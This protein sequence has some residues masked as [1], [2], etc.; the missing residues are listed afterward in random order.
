MSRSPKRS[1]FRDPIQIIVN[2]EISEYERDDYVYDLLHRNPLVFGSGVGMNNILCMF[3]KMSEGVR[4]NGRAYFDNIDQIV[5]AFMDMKLGGYVDVSHFILSLDLGGPRE[6]AVSVIKRL[7]ECYLLYEL[8]DH[9]GIFVSVQ[10]IDFLRDRRYRRYFLTDNG[11]VAK[12]VAF[13]NYPLTGITDT[14]IKG[15]PL[16]PIKLYDLIPDVYGRCHW[17]DEMC[18]V[19]VHG[20]VDYDRNILFY[21]T[22]EI[23]EHLEEIIRDIL[24]YRKGKIT[25]YDYIGNMS[26]IIFSCNLVPI[27]ENSDDYDYDYY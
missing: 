27:I 25:R 24:K 16:G 10:T 21:A 23:S 15:M 17:R 26:S 11:I 7:L 8:P 4:E 6:Y 2:N 12:P 18:E 5:H 1:P 13:A 20:F 14:P 19:N 22:D 3:K 9:L